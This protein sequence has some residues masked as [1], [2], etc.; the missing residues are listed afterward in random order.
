MNTTRKTLK[1]ALLL[2]SL[3]AW[4]ALAAAGQDVTLTS[5]GK[6]PGKP[7]E[8][9]QQQIDAL[10]LE[11]ADLQTQLDAMV[12]FDCA[13]GQSVVGFNASG[14]ICA[15]SPVG[16]EGPQGIQGPPGADGTNG[17]V[18]ADCTA[19]QI[20]D[21]NGAP[22]DLFNCDLTQANLAGADLRDSDLSGARLFGANLSGANLGCVD[23][24]TIT[25][26]TNLTDADLRFADLTDANLFGANLRGANLYVANLFGAIL[27]AAD[28]TGAVLP[29]A[30][31]PFAVV[32]DTTCPDGTNTDTNGGTCEGHP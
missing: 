32:F 22:Y 2:L 21:L 15:P 30:T 9:L 27:G 20:G 1:T 17:A 14:P 10:L 7:F 26:C 8:H 16:P 31:L 11:A 24:F 23:P 29:G 18:G 25:G 19:V 3:I 28:L 12:P 13:A 5:D 6:V 4:A